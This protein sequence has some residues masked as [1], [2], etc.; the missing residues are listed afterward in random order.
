[1]QVIALDSAVIAIAV[2]AY[3]ETKRLPKAKVQL[4]KWA[5]AAMYA[6]YIVALQA[7]IQFLQN[8]DVLGEVVIGDSRSYTVTVWALKL[9]TATF[10]GFQFGSYLSNTTNPGEQDVQLLLSQ[11][12]SVQQLMKQLQAKHN[13]PETS[14]LPAD[15]EKTAIPEVI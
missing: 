7:I 4:S 13:L 3:L 14:D 1:M 5:Y 12:E 15:G 10:A 8:F 2:A 11:A 6:G 9:S